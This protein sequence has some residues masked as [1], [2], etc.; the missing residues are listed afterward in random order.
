MR[1]YTDYISGL[2]QNLI[3]DYQVELLE[4]RDLH[5][6]VNRLY[7]KQSRLLAKLARLLY[8]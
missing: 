7:A 6:K 3:M 8:G 1:S 5:T 4:V 2:R